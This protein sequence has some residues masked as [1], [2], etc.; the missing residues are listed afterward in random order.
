MFGFKLQIP[1]ENARS[2]KSW[3]KRALVGP[4]T[5]ESQGRP[6]SSCGLSGAL[7]LH[8]SSIWVQG[9]VLPVHYLLPP[10]TDGPPRGEGSCHGTS[11]VSCPGPP[12]KARGSSCV[13]AKSPPRWSLLLAVGRGSSRALTG[14]SWVTQP[15]AQSQGWVCT[16]PGIGASTT[17]VA[18]GACSQVGRGGRKV[19][20]QRDEK[21]PGIPTHTRGSSPLSRML[22]PQAKCHFPAGAGRAMGGRCRGSPPCVPR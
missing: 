18:F 3:V 7:S 5:A 6:E 4:M 22:A 8:T 2:Q 13:A 1:P 19:T 21:G 9:Q 11:S 14:W 10:F 20:G 15:P 16:G 17:A 12:W